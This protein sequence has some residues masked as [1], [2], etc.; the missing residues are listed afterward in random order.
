MTVTLERVPG[1]LAGLVT[2]SVAGCGADAE[3]SKDRDIRTREPTAEAWVAHPPAVV[4][5]SQVLESEPW[6]GQGC[7]D[8]T[9]MLAA[10][11]VTEC[12]PESSQPH[13]APRRAG[14]SHCLAPAGARPGSTLARVSGAGWRWAS[15]PASWQPDFLRVTGDRW[16]RN[17]SSPGPPVA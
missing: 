11:S 10:L 14:F 17:R 2:N 4:C 6:T 8:S 7:G 3:A 5:P 12:Y 16:Q 13:R 1:A 15:L 9:E